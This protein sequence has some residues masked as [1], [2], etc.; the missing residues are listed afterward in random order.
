MTHFVIY[1]LGPDHAAYGADAGKF[2]VT[3]ADIEREF[4]GPMGE[5]DARL[6]ASALNSCQAIVDRW[7]PVTSPRPHGSAPRW[8]PTQTGGRH[9][10]PNRTI[11]H[12]TGGSE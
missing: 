9:C 11:H 8:S 4:S 12:S 3:I 1:Q 7:E 5:E 6:L 10:P 2:I